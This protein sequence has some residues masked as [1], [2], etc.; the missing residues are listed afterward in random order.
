MFCSECNRENQFTGSAKENPQHWLRRVQFS[1]LASKLSE[2]QLLC[3]ACAL[4][5]GDAAC[6]LDTVHVAD[7]SD[8]KQQFL[9][10][11]GPSVDA[12]LADQLAARQ[13][14]DESARD[15]ADRHQ[16]LTFQL[17]SKGA[18]VPPILALRHFVQGLALPVR[19]KVVLARPSTFQKARE[20]AEYFEQLQNEAELFRDTSEPIFVHYTTQAVITEPEFQ[21][22][23]ATHSTY[24]DKLLYLTDKLQR[25]KLQLADFRFNCDERGLQPVDVGLDFDDS[26]DTSDSFP[27]HNDYNSDSGDELDQWSDSDTSGTCEEHVDNVDNFV[28]ED[29]YASSYHTANSVSKAESQITKFKP[30]EQIVTITQV[31]QVGDAEEADMASLQLSCAKDPTHPPLQSFPAVELLQESNMTNEA[32]DMPSTACALDV[33]ISPSNIDKMP[34]IEPAFASQLLG[35]SAQTSLQL[36]PISKRQS[37]IDCKSISGCAF[38]KCSA[39]ACK[40]APTPPLQAAYKSQAADETFMMSPCSCNMPLDTR[41]KHDSCMPSNIAANTALSA[42]IWPLVQKGTSAAPWALMTCNPQSFTTT[43]Q[44]PASHINTACEPV[45][46]TLNLETLTSPK[47]TNTPNAKQDLPERLVLHVSFDPF[48]VSALVTLPKHNSTVMYYFQR[49]D[50]PGQ[51]WTPAH[52]QHWSFDPGGSMWSFYPQQII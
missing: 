5:S 42:D 40:P 36:D 48:Q 41:C 44:V 13:R 35:P 20:L 11:F 17:A 46:C 3:Q 15:F 7:W 14:E 28:E 23:T 10:R 38:D 12:L 9:E 4:L 37:E 18:S 52:S 25:L 39:V 45:S 19:Q 16:S 31:V 2:E 43:E 26:S 47:L 32:S 27:S 8:F 29:M 22:A 6:W 24:E 21:P 51:A 34:S 33:A 1:A 50:L 30:V 49:P